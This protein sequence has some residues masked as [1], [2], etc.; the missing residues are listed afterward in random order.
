MCDGD[1]G[2]GDTLNISHTLEHTSYKIEWPN[3]KGENVN[4]KIIKLTNYLFSSDACRCKLLS[5]LFSGA[6]RRRR[7]KNCD[8][9]CSRTS[10]ASV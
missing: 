8:V 9:G 6:E 2:S 3:V 4:R 1:G 10:R 5:L 7:V